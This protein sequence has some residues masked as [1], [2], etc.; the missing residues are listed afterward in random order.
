M[1]LLTIPYTNTSRNVNEAG[2]VQVRGVLRT[3]GEGVVLEFTRARHLYG[4][5]ELLD[6]IRTAV[7]PWF[8]I[9]SLEF[10]RRFPLRGVLILRTRSLRTLRDVP[11]TRGNEAVLY[12]ARGDRLAA[13]ELAASVELAL[14][15]HRLA[16]LQAPYSP[17]ALP[18]R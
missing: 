1:E 4:Q 18:P 11:H 16:A 5:S 17:P 2:Y 12:V 15:D 7:I 8:D 6:D 10:R 14:A 9:Q 3:E 13:R